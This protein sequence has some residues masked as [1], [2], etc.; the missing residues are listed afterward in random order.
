MDLYKTVHDSITPEEDPGAEQRLDP[1]SKAT[2]K[3]IAT[4]SSRAFFWKQLAQ[5]AL[6]AMAIFGGIAIGGGAAGMSA[7]QT[8]AV[9]VA[10]GG[11]G[12]VS[13]LIA[14]R[15]DIKNEVS[16]EELYAKRTGQC[17]ADSIVEKSQTLNHILHPEKSH[18]SLP[19]MPYQE[20]QH[21]SGRFQQREEAP[22]E[23]QAA[24]LPDT[25]IR[26]NELVG[27]QIVLPAERTLH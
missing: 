10:S 2:L 9:A 15:I 19:P 16:L 20:E 14:H 17:V 22:Q 5:Y 3:H 21:L 25:R 11:V 8:L 23:Q 6:T 12:L 27:E 18:A 1:Q 7:L 4:N 13:S 26:S 24:A